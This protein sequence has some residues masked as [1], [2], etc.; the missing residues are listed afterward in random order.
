[1]ND[2]P[3]IIYWGKRNVFLTEVG[4]HME[5]Y[6]GKYLLYPY[7]SNGSATFDAE[8]F[9]SVKAVRSALKEYQRFYPT[10]EIIRM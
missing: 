8:G 3:N 6:K 2:K 1:M 10:A 4:Q 7:D 5:I 9:D